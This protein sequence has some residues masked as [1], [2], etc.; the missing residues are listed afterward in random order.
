M[1]FIDETQ[2]TKDGELTLFEFPR[3]SPYRHKQQTLKQ[4]PL[5]KQISPFLNPKL[6]GRRRRR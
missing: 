6:L 1:S 4:E 2:G 5:I 3:G